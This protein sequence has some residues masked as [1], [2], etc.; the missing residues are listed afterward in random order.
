MSAGIV[1]ILVNEAMPGIVKIGF[2]KDELINRIKGLDST[3]I[4]LPFECFC[5]VEVPDCRKVEQ[6]VHDV[7]GD[8]RI[9]TNREFFRVSPER[10][11]SA[12]MLTGGKDI[13]PA[14][15]EIISTSDDR[16]AIQATRRRAENANFGMIGI[17]IG[18]TL[19]FSKDA[20]RTC[21][22]YD[23]RK[24]QM[25]GEILSV[26]KSALKVLHE[27]GYNWQ[28]VNGWAYWSYQGKTLDEHFLG[29]DDD[30]A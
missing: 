15:S 6:L 29:L 8:Q 5:A 14:E 11:R 18:S 7:F 12:L 9:R 20:N 4:P 27:L 25:D 13:T 23:D 16:Q 17:S 24:V 30:V 10:V 19:V 28:T 1:Y 22:V 3:S 21:T 2:T 26:S